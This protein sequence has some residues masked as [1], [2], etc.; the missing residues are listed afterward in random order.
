VLLQLGKEWQVVF[1]G[2]SGI[3]RFRGTNVGQAWDTAKGV[4]EA[5]QE[6]MAGYRAHALGIS[7][8]LCRG[9]PFQ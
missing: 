6:Q 2:A 4:P 1:Y 5:F 7:G 9:S 8:R 3:E